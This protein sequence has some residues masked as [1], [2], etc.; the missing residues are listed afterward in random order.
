MNLTVTLGETNKDE[1]EEL[2]E[3]LKEKSAEPDGIQGH[4][5]KKE[6]IT[7]KS[8]GDKRVP[9]SA[10]IDLGLSG[11]IEAASAQKTRVLAEISELER[12]KRWKDI[13]ALAYPI[14]EKYP[15]LV[16]MEMD[17]E[18]RRK[19]GFALV[20]CSMHQKA[21][22]LLIPMAE[23]SP[24]D[25]MANFS[26][27]YAAYDALYLHKKRQLPLS[28]KEKE[29][30]VD[31]AHSHFQ[32]C[33]DIRPLGVNAFY[34][35][36]MLYKEIEDKPRKA[37]PLFEKAIGNWDL[38]DNEKRVEHHQERPKFIKSLYHLASCYLRRS[39]PS[40]SLKLLERLMKEDEATNFLSPL[41]KHFAMGKTLYRMGRYKDALDHLRTAAHAAAG[42]RPPDYVIELSAGC[43]LMMNE[44]QKAL[45]EINKI[46]LKNMRPYVRW[47]R[48]DILSAMNRHHEALV[49][50][51]G[52]L[53]RD[54][55]SK[56]K[57]LLRM[58]RIYYSLS[59]YEKALG[60]A[61][62]ASIFFEK[63]YGN[64]LKDADFLEA[65]CMLGLGKCH[66]ARLKLE[67]LERE[68][69]SSPGFRKAL[70]DAKTACAERETGKCNKKKILH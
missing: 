30:L 61:K 23:K 38:M 45:S 6:F 12:E 44:T 26:V 40:Q 21:L 20:R 69:F 48:A 2:K 60:C 50:L 66:A 52:A 7:S 1:L 25:F 29:R 28:Q 51:E 47:R 34:R 57:T 43:L 36:A 33:I 65:V 22:K 17:L 19:L 59:G 56:H 5:G 58:S 16:D 31:L 3:R 14:E 68:G 18:L 15:L 41:F 63:R 10:P 4:G 37:I 64:R 54:G 46:P 13:L 24:E 35:K 11:Q 53:D 67:D 42:G 9:T 27:A 32:N 55:M 39:L 49:T 70:V 62:K 8:Q